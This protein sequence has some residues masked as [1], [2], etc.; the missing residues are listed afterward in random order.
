MSDEFTISSLIKFLYIQRVK[1]F[2]VPTQPHFDPISVKFFIDKLKSCNQYLEYGTG[3]STFLA[4]KLGKDFIAVDSDRYF[5]QAVKKKIESSGYAC[6]G[7]QV[8]R[9]ADI[10]LTKEW[11]QPLFQQ[12]IK[13]RLKK[14]ATYSDFPIRGINSFLP[15]LILIDGRFRVAC[16][17]KTIKYLQNKIN[18]TILVDDYVG[19]NQY[20]E[21][22]RFANLVKLEGRMAVFTQKDEINLIDLDCSIEKYTTDFR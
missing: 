7:T 19:R 20:K 12:R 13:S 8:L 14:W 16:A 6:K 18:Y 2:D 17:L 11:G 15:D 22:E 21:I 3:G 4:A 9:H 1:G 10:G 5:L